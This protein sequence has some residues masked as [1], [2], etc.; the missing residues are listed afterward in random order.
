MPCYNDSK[1]GKVRM[2]KMTENL[3]TSVL[4]APRL[5]NL[6]RVLQWQARRLPIMFAC[7]FLHI[8]VQN[9]LRNDRII[10][11]SSHATN[12]HNNST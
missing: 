12:Y 4:D 7:R 3:A 8:V 5:E 10:T 11:Y 9:L 6:L 1:K 2:R